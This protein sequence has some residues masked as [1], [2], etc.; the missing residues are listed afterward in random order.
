VNVRYDKGQKMLH[1]YSRISPDILERFSQSFDHMKVLYAHMMDL[2]LIFQ[3]VVGCCHGN[4]ITLQNFYQRRLIRLAFVARML[5]N[6]LQYHGPAV[7]INSGDD[8]ATSSK[9]LVNFCLVT[10]EMTGLICVSMYLYWAKIDLTPAF[11]V[12][13]FR[14]PRNIVTLMDA[15]TAAMIRLHLI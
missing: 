10:P 5:E 3:F 13:P 1:R 9:N 7:C 8:G 6:E 11:I 12:L 2:Y 4:Q 15:L 14:M